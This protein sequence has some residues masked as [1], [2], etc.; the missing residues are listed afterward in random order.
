MTDDQAKILEQKLDLILERLPT[1][2]ALGELLVEADYVT[3]ARGLSPKT[4][5][6][7]GVDKYQDRGHRKLLIKLQD[8]DAVLKRKRK[9]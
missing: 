2:D 3:K 6:K 9:R 1:F 8:V 5:A 4:I 7:N